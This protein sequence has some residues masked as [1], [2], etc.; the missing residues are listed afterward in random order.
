VRFVESYGLLSK[1]HAAR[2]YWGEMIHGE[3]PNLGCLR[4]CVHEFVERLSKD[5]AAGKCSVY[6]FRE[7]S[8]LLCD[9]GCERL[10]ERLLLDG[11][12]LFGP[13]QLVFQTP[14]DAASSVYAVR[15]WMAMGTPT[16]SPPLIYNIA[17]YE[18]RGGWFDGTQN[19]IV[20]HVFS[21]GGGSD[22]GE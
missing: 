21:A 12:A 6:H 8:G 14:A 10:E 2:L 22:H 1:V 13:Q 11:S 17:W 7:H 20:A 16:S 9:L 19:V 4:S 15:T 5:A 3:W 18:N